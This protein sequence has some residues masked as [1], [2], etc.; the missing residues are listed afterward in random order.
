MLTDPENSDFSL[1]DGSPA[2]GFGCLTFDDSRTDFESISP[3]RSST[4]D[5]RETLSGTIS[6]STHLT[7]EVIHV[8]GDVFIENGVILSFEAGAQVIFDGNY[9]FDVQGTVKP[10]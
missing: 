10:I 7:A 4:S 2:A 8:V 1:E 6:E 9:S 5:S 3:L